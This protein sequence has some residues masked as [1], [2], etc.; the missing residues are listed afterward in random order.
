[1]AGALQQ[2]FGGVQLDRKIANL[3]DELPIE[4]ST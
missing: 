3:R 1:M 4:F 2:G